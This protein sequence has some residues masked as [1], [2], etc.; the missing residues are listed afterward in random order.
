MPSQEGNPRVDPPE[1]DP[2]NS[3][4][5]YVPPESDSGLPPSVQSMETTITLST[6]S[7]DLSSL[8]VHPP[9][10]HASSVN[11]ELYL[12]AF[13]TPRIPTE[14]PINLPSNPERCLP[15]TE[16]QENASQDIKVKNIAVLDTIME[17][18]RTHM[19]T[20]DYHAD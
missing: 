16:P 19:P 13:I 14:S 3:T 17:L 8:Q 2:H 20:H 15:H 10:S 5:P 4:D 1:S 7:E 12:L 9:S 6:N 11:R 18:L